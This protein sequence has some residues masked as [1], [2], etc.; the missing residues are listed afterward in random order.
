MDARL[1]TRFQPQA[2]PFLVHSFRQEGTEKRRREIL[3]GEQGGEWISSY[4]KDTSRGAPEGLRIWGTPR[5]TPAP[6][7]AV[8]SLAAVY[9]VRSAIA[10]GLSETRFAM[11]DKQRVWDVRVTLAEPEVIETPAGRFRARRV[12]LA[13]ERIDP[14]VEEESDEDGDTGEFAGPFGIKG[15]IGL[16]LEERTGIPLVI[17]GELPVVLGDLSLDMKLVAHSGTPPTFAPLTE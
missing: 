16:W 5:E 6:R 12:Q 11:L 15:D 9:L 8:D 3:A 2:W 13:T 7:G 4:R 14:W 1:E 17:D 10:E